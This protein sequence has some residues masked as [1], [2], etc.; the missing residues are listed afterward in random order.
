MS[1][2]TWPAYVA[3]IGGVLVYVVLFVPMLVV[4]YRRYGR[5]SGRRLLV[6]AA[7]AVYGVALVA[8]TLLPVPR[9]DFAEWCARYG[10][11]EAQL[12]PLQFVDDIA[13]E[14]HSLE[15]A[16]VLSSR[17]VLQLVLNVVLFVPWG[18]FCRRFLGWGLVASVAS[19]FGMSLLIEVTQYSGVFGLI[20][21]SYRLG[22]VDDVLSN[23]LGALIGA[24]VAPVVLR[25]L[26]RPADLQPERKRARPV[27][28]GRR[29]LGILIDGLLFVVVGAV[30]DAGY[31]LVLLAGAR[32]LPVRETAA[33]VLLAGVVPLLLVFVVPALSGTGASWGMRTVWLEPSWVEASGTSRRR[34]LRA[35]VPGGLWGLLVTLGRSPDAGAWATVGDVADGLALSV[36]VIALAAVPVTRNHRGLSGVVSRSGL[37]DSRSPDRGLL[38]SSPSRSILRGK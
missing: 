36:A 12:R 7:A 14:T 3:V 31:R 13:R 28:S 30:L 27:T 25:W 26:P 8:Y 35:S 23:T 9:G 15:P 2:W 21:C 1:R 29:W 38:R 22:D 10:Y 32:P 4:Q 37:T 17:A 18:A 5:P 6:A 24:A 11:R 20:G 33:D 16:A 19:A 34:L